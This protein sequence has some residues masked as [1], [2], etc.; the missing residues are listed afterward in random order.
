VSAL[1]ARDAERVLRFVAD[2][3]DIGG[4]EPF[5]PEI[6]GRLAAI[7]PA[8]WVAYQEKHA[9][10]GD[11]LVDRQR[12]SFD[13]VYPGIEFD[14][15]VARDESPVRPRTAAAARFLGVPDDEARSG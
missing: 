9:G 1:T 14:C 2:A 8:D 12:P 5:T 11:L 7:I 6:L 15:I 4:D 3:E 13:D 10:G